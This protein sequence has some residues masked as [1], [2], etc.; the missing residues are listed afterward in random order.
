MQKNTIQDTILNEKSNIKSPPGYC[1]IRENKPK[2]RSKDVRVAFIIRDTILF[3]E[4]KLKTSD[5]HLGIEAVELNT[6]GKNMK[7][8]DTYKPP[9]SSCD[10]GY[11]T[12]I[13][14]LLELNDC[15]AVS[16][17]NA[18]SPL[19]HSKLL[20]D[21]RGNKI[22]HEIYFSKYIVFNKK[23]Q[24]TSNWFLQKLHGHVSPAQ[25]LHR[26]RLAH[27]VRIMLK[28]FTNYSIFHRWPQNRHNT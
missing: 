22:A 21:T 13:S 15:I 14:K 9:L 25:A 18:R 7:L 12:S 17:F 28:P 20:E 1:I 4:L 27:G 8:V 2:W 19:R 11:K 10:S 16:E 26:H 24:H 23:N 5:I 3:G 6:N